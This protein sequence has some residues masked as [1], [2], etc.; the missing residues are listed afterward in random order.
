MAFLA[1]VEHCIHSMQIFTYFY[2]C[3]H[4]AINSILSICAFLLPGARWLRKWRGGISDQYNTRLSL[5]LCLIFKLETDILDL[6]DRVQRG[7][8]KGECRV[9]VGQKMFPE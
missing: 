9:K 8:E 7:G 2:Q 3:C 6:L 1:I 5:V 4:E